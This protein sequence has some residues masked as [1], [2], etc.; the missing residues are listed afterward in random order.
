LDNNRIKLKHVSVSTFKA[1]VS[2]LEN[3]FGFAPFRIP[4]I[5]VVSTSMTIKNQNMH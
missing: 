1:H 4:C 2:M 3:G 5:Y